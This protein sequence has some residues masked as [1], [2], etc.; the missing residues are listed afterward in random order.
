MQCRCYHR[1][2]CMPFMGRNGGH[3]TSKTECNRFSF[4]SYQRDVR[5][6]SQ[7]YE[8]VLIVVKVNE[9]GS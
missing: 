4:A 9:N 8:D 3:D 6:R 1:L 5:L 2:A 7:R